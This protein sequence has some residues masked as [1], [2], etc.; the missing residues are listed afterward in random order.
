MSTHFVGARDPEPSGRD[1]DQA[2]LLVALRLGVF[3]VSLDVRVVAPLLP[4]V[5]AHFHVPLSR[6]GWLVTA[7]LLPYG[8]FQLA[9]GP[10]A[11]RYGKVTVASSAM[12]VFTV[13]TACCGLFSSFAG[14]VACRALTGAA[15]AAMIP[16]TLA[17]VGD[18]V[19]YSRRQAVIGGLM[20]SSAAGQ[21]FGTAFGG[22][23]AAVLSWRSVFPALGVIAL[24]ATA[25]LFAFRGREL[26][27]PRAPGA[28]RPRYREILRAPQMR[29]LL[30]L[31]ATEGFLFSGSYAYLSGLLEHRFGMTPLPIGLV[32]GSVGA[33][34]LA[35][36]RLLPR[37]VSKLPERRL[38]VIGGTCMGSAY[39][40]SSLASHWVV[41]L[42]A[43]VGMGFGFILCHSTLQ[44]R[45][46]EAF[47]R[48]RGTAVTLFAFSLFLGSGTGTAFF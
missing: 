25:G 5:A 1:H 15:A 3:T 4:T 2:A 40:A 47:P 33:A 8:L 22:T 36:A 34:Q 17:Y 26:R 7:Y 19:P 30:A 31:V 10:L 39:L 43:C 23:V 11:D 13:G 20:A 16:L 38:L 21:A 29:A 37:L 35:A 18:T 42:V 24:G 27:Q 41:V 6:A 14:I 9:Y 12:A 45:A 32:L 28:E 46:T 44:T 48:A